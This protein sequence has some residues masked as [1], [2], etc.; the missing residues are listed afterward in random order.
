MTVVYD[1]GALIA[2]D[3]SAREVW[4]DHRARL[5]LGL[6][7]VTTAPVVAQVSRSARQAQLR[8]FLRGCETVPFADDLAHE[9]GALAG[10]AE[11]SDV[12][13]VHVVL[14]AHRHGYGVVTSDERDLRPIVTALGRAVPLIPV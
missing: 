12:V 13:G 5:E 9:V 7:P 11:A 2:A 10:K 3:R 14:V 1:A 6:L 4:A 8:R